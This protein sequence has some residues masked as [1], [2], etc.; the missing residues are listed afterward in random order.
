MPKKHPPISKKDES[1]E[2]EQSESESEQSES[3]SEKSESESDEELSKKMQSVTVASKNSKSSSKKPVEMK[4]VKQVKHITEIINT[5]PKRTL[6]TYNHYVSEKLKEFRLK[7]PGRE[8]TKYMKMAAA[9]WS[10]MSISQK[11][12][13]AKKIASSA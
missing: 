6:T 12:A 9:S 3:E 2:S 1:S 7:Y 4:P 8:S 5:P 13:F 11:E 10:K